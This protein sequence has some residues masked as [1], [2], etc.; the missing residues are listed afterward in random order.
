M[1]MSSNAGF[2]SPEHNVGRPSYVNNIYLV[3]GF[4]LVEEHGCQG[5]GSFPY[6][7]LVKPC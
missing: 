7:A 5:H 2:S 1:N 4:R 6:M 3:K